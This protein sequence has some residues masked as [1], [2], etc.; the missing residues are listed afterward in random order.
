M[1]FLTL[2]WDI[3]Q[4]QAQVPDKGNR[5]GSVD[6]KNSTQAAAWR[7]GMAWCVWGLW[8][9]CCPWGIPGEDGKGSHNSKGILAPNTLCTPHWVCNRYLVKQEEK[10]RRKEENISNIGLKANVFL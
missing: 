10:E 7:C 6:S 9:V 1:I 4:S 3:L 8:A 2:K 5:E